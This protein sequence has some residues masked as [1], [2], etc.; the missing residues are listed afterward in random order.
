[1][2]KCQISDYIPFNIIKCLSG[3]L[4]ILWLESLLV[5]ICAILQNY[6]YVDILKGKSQRI[7]MFR[8]E[9]DIEKNVI[10]FKG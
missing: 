4:N 10:A 7:K 3:Q 1:M 8:L 9:I 6:L 5:C 2:A